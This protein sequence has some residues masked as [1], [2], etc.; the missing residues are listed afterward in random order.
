GVVFLKRGKA[1]SDV[2]YT[3]DI[4]ES[5]VNTVQDHGGVLTLD[6][7]ESHRT[8]ETAAVSV[9]Y[10]GVDVFEHP[11][12][13]QGFAAL[14]MLKIMETFDF[15]AFDALSEDR[16]HLMIE[17]KKLAY[18]DLHHHCADPSFYKAPLEK[19]LSKDY[20][21]ERA[22]TIDSLSAMNDY[23]SGLSLGNDTVYLATADGEEGAVS[24][25]NS[26]YK[27]IGSGLVAPGTGIKL[28]NRGHLFSF[29]PDHPNCY[30]PKKLPFHTII[31]GALYKN[32][33]LMGMFGI[34]GGAHQAQAHAQF[35]S[36]L[37]DYEMT[38]QEAMDYPRFNHDHKTN[39]VGLEM[40]IPLLVEEELRKRGHQV[41]HNDSVKYFGGGQAILR[42]NEDTW[43][44]GSDHRKDGHAAGF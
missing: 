8:E 19:L 21:G 28:Q 6:D 40:G 17:A 27:G 7:L 38:P 25:I 41:E 30:A 29:D 42:F 20:A 26:L 39:T 37:I 2:F 5:I 12:N 35:V 34:M 10:R 4:D 36:N 22:K 32:K 3:G 43:I 16:F 14:S 44:A 24:F 11:P 15:S 23:S 13:G 33:K 9:S 31:P 18:A 1:G